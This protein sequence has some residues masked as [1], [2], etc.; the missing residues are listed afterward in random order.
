MIKKLKNTVSWTYAISE[1]N[2]EEIAGMFYKKELQKT[3]QTQ[4]RVEKAIKR[5]EDKLYGKW[6]GCDSLFN[7][8]INKNDIL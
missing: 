4:F 8:W 2:G 1:Y 6:K 7:S 3:N 5:K